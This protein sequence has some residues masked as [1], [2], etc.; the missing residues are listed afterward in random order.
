MLDTLYTPLP[1]S[2]DRIKH[3]LRAALAEIDEVLDEIAAGEV[4]WSDLPTKD[5]RIEGRLW[6]APDRTLKVS[7]GRQFK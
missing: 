4:N 7:A 6:I 2:L 1:D 5:P 3:Y